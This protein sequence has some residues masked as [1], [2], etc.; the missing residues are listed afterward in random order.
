MSSVALKLR[1]FGVESDD[2]SAMLSRS[3]AFTPAGT[4]EV[5]GSCERLSSEFDKLEAQY[6]Q[7]IAAQAQALELAFQKELEVLQQS[8][9]AQLKLGLHQCL[10]ALFPALAEASLRRGLEREIQTSVMQALP[11]SLSVQISPD[12][13][14]AVEVPSGVQLDEDPDLRGQRVEIIHGES[15]TRLDPQAILNT[16]LAIL[17]S[18]N[19]E[20]LAT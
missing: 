19:P 5:C 2:L 16:C 9:E 17:N 14:G 18:E 20:E 8:L 6:A 13:S 1:D 4:E 15:R 10:S 11:G 7:N 3:L 12:L